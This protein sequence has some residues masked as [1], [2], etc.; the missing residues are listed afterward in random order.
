MSILYKNGDIRTINPL[1]DEGNK[2]I[3]TEGI[4]SIILDGSWGTACAG[5]NLVAEDYTVY[6]DIPDIRIEFY[7]E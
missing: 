2:R 4:D 3:K 5:P 7:G 6:E 1:F